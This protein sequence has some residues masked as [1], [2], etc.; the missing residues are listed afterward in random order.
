MNNPQA[1]S[2]S[3]FDSATEIADAAE[4]A[5]FLDEACDGDS[6]L[7]AEVEALLAAAAQAGSFMQEPATSA[8]PTRVHE[9]PI[10]CVGTVIGP[11]K[12]LQ[13]IGEGGMG[14]VFM[15]EQ[16]RPVV[17]K[18]ALK[19]IKPGM[20]SRQVIARFEAERQAL[21]LM[22]HPNIARVLDA[23]A[24]ESGRLYF[25]MELVN[26]IA[27][28]QFCD[29]RQLSTRQRLELFV[30]VCQAVQHAHQKGVV[31]RD[32]KPTNVLV[33]EYDDQAVPK[34]IDF[35][36]AKATGQRL[37]ERTMFTEFGQ[38][39][40]TVE[41]MSP[42]Q[43]K[44]NQLDID[45]RTDVYSLGVL[46]YELLT[47]ATPFDR[48]RLHSAAF[49]EVL[50]I[51][52][53][54]EPP[55]PSTRLNSSDAL[56]AI[57]ACRHSEPQKLTK[58]VRGELDWIVMK[59][60]EKDRNRRYD[61]PS[62]LAGDIDRYLRD[63]PVQ[64]GPPSASYK[65]RK[66]ARKHRGPLA[67]GAAFVL[68][69]AAASVVSTWQAVRATRAER[70]VAR[71]RDQVLA[72]KN[73]KEEA[74][75]LTVQA[76]KEEA[77]QRAAAEEQRRQADSQR[78]AAEAR[79]LEAVKLQR[80][81]EERLATG[82]IAAG[83]AAL[84]LG[85][86][87]AR[88]SY[89]EAWDVERRLGLSQLPATTGLLASYVDQPPPL[90]GAD[91]RHGGAGGYE[92]HGRGRL[93]V[94]FSPDGRS[95]ASASKNGSLIYWDVATGRSIRNFPRRPPGYYDVKFAPDGRSVLTAGA[96]GN[97]RLWDLTTG[98]QVRVFSGHGKE[99]RAVAFSA[100]GETIASGGY[101]FKVRLWDVASGSELQRFDMPSFVESVTFS[102]DGRR[103]MAGGEPSVIR[104]W[105]V[106]TGKQLHELSDPLGA[107]KLGLAFAPDG[108][109]VLSGCLNHRMLQLDLET[110][111]IIRAFDGHT[112]SITDVAFSP[113]GHRALSASYDR[114]V[115]LWDTA[116]GQQLRVWRGH[117][118]ALH[119]AAFSPDGRL[120]ISADEGG[121]IKLWDLQEEKD[122]ETFRRHTGR[123]I[124]LVISADG[125][126]VLSGS[127]DKSIRLWDVA[128]RLP[129]RTIA[130]GDSPVWGVALSRDG[131]TAVS[132]HEDKTLSV[133]DIATGNRRRKLVGHTDTVTAVA[134]SRDGTALSASSDKTLRLWNLDTGDTIRTFAGHSEKVRKVIFAAD[135]RTALS[136]SFDNTLK[137]WDVTTGSVL[138]TFTGH[139]HWIIGVAISPD[140]RTA[141]S[142]G[143]DRQ[144][145]L[146]DLATGKNLCFVS[147]ASDVVASVA[148]SPDGK[149]LLCGSLDGHIGLWDLAA[150]R[151]LR[152]FFQSAE[153]VT[154]VTFCP[155]GAMA[156]SGARDG[157]IRRWN[158]DRPAR[159]E[160]FAKSLPPARAALARDPE[161]AKALA[162]FGRWYAFRGVYDWAAEFLE[163]ARAGG[164]D[165]SSLDLAR[166]Y[167]H[168]DK[169]DEAAREF[170]DALRRRE[171]PGD[172]LAACLAA[173]AELQSGGDK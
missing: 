83:D 163:K 156:L 33:A 55:K 143:W 149:L 64:A 118:D 152:D 30:P 169:R 73:R 45:T 21:A 62:G 137:L 86:A 3:V 79:R 78:L 12:L 109:T 162:E 17:R 102:P 74:L 14:V 47:G 112:G 71:E 65:L 67:V 127:F 142:S 57:A 134:L 77:K 139:S 10:E 95:A 133:W 114:T 113:D 136:G 130:T 150:R 29:E 135:G 160:E 93:F 35:G 154:C 72:E 60:L 92:G 46:L 58:L 36:V 132:A 97:L 105:D 48:R 39:L 40:G 172:Y 122:L 87:E 147:A 161:D 124:S 110:G 120:V 170:Q 173:V 6:A 75:R 89:Q 28:T 115:R 84:A 153:G 53:E 100:N 146:W 165:V 155:D 23:G 104:L 111:N 117:I 121:V 69:L 49:D 2:R 157:I 26:G 9:R 98:T 108:R 82:L 16:T 99:V 44:L 19:I 166:C 159:Y 25:V 5:A 56:P 168:L 129:L 144:W 4:R 20:D 101:D 164:G 167:W 1:R 70:Q 54:E 38:V 27:I 31:H 51:I 13:Q 42:E 88:D 148:F 103:L 107:A 34:V 140:G 91:G 37:T 171:A 119:S 41:Y 59:A 22:D 138:R 32:I 125:R 145:A 15:A 90:T 141:V 128:T 80:T 68:L 96:D 76:Q 123:V 81:A 116:T 106:A 7:R 18:V 151:Q 63:E 11:Y 158:W 43:A 52:R 50:R 85:R 66:L 131:R 8:Y 24:T 126:T 94:A 61:T